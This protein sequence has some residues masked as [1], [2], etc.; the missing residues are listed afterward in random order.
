MP[1]QDRQLKELN[2][3]LQKMQRESTKTFFQVNSR[4]KSKRI[5]ELLEFFVGIILLSFGL[6][7]IFQSSEVNTSL[8]L[9]NII[10]FL[11]GI[12]IL[13]FN[14]NNI[15]SWIVTILGLVII[16]LTIILTLKINSQQ[17]SIFNYFIMFCFVALGLALL[18][19][20][21]YKNKNNILHKN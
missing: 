8:N 19:L 7:L 1:K 14:K 2:D 16:L 10:P 4:I 18:F 20:A 15:F 11:I 6:F 12:T 3:T 17:V 21:I 13:F 9:F 5:L